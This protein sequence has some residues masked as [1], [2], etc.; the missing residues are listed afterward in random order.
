MKIRDRIFKNYLDDG[1]KILH[2]AHKHI[3]VLK[4]DSAKTIFF[5][6][7]LPTGLYFLVPRAL[8]IF[9]IWWVIGLGSFIYHIIDWY[10]DTWLLTNLGIIGITRQG[11]LDV[12]ATRVEYHMI[13]GISYNIKGVLQTIFNYGT[14]TVD[15]LGAQTSV[16]LH[17]ASSPKKL[18]RLVM[19]YQEKYVYDRSIRDHNALKG[20]LSDMIAYHAQNNKIEIPKNKKN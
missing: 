2:I 9:V 13:E 18:E 6:L 3:L 16:I 14:V 7:I 10:Y 4:I 17:D 15:K 19:R 11:L 1:E 8:P 5:G 20:M 12:T